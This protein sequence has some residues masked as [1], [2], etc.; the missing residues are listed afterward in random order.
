MKAG[1]KIII[2][3]LLVPIGGSNAFNL[4]LLD[5]RHKSNKSKCQNLF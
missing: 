5:S 2:I 3:D 4:E 1:N